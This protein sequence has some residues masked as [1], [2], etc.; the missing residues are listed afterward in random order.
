MKYF[1]RT[2]PEKRGFNIN[3]S[4]GKLGC[5][6]FNCSTEGSFFRGSAIENTP[7]DP[8][9]SS[10]AESGNYQA[11]TLSSSFPEEAKIPL[12]K[13]HVCRAGEWKV[14]FSSKPFTV[15]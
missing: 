15:Q 8:T 10:Y 3:K 13:G 11:F 9:V 5:Q 12:F 1:R 4:T 14:S 6:A 2:G 7:L